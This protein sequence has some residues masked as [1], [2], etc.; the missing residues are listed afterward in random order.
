MQMAVYLAFRGP[1]LLR[2]AW[3]FQVAQAHTIGVGIPVNRGKAQYAFIF[4]ADGTIDDEPERRGDPTFTS[5]SERLRG[6]PQPPKGYLSKYIEA[7]NQALAKEMNET[8]F[9]QRLK[10]YWAS[11]IMRLGSTD[12]CFKPSL[13]GI[14]NWQEFSRYIGEGN[15]YAGDVI[16]A[17]GMLDI[18]D[19]GSIP[20][21][22]YLCLIGDLASVKSLTAEH[23]GR[24]L[25]T[26][27]DDKGNSALHFACMGGH[28][29]IA[30][31]LLREK[32]V[33][34]SRPNNVGTLPL[35]WLFMF[36]DN[37]IDKMAELLSDLENDNMVSAG[38]RIRLHFLWL[39]G[40]P[41]HWAVSCRNRAAVQSLLRIGVNIDEEYQ[42]YTALAKA[43]ELHTPEIV[44]LLLEN[45]AQFKSIGPFGRSAM[46]FVA[47]NAP[48]I[49]RRI[50]HGT[51][52]GRNQDLKKAVRETICKLE[53]FGCN[54]NSTDKHGNTPLHKAVA[55]PLERGDM[56]D[57]Y[58]ARALIQNDADR[59]VQ[60]DDGDTIL[61]LAIKSYWCD[62]PN[63]LDL[64]KLLLDDSIP[65]TNETPL[66]ITQ[67]DRNGRHTLL[68]TAYVG[69]GA[70]YIRLLTDKISGDRDTA[71]AALLASDNYGNNFMTL[72]ETSFEEKM[73]FVGREMKRLEDIGLGVAPHPDCS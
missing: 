45:G 66:Q 8:Y 38:L 51:R 53:F 22:H 71:T 35:H 9:S 19:Q 55:S 40:P 15:S 62:R 59:N 52:H 67:R 24:E 26:L 34:K 10:V 42:G 37:D 2:S 14:K 21:L 11:T 4:A 60:N 50:L 25:L 29:G 56:D 36:P 18:T 7:C 58:V 28:T 6:V 65:L 31:Y 72:A 44:H 54:I 70:T 43:V 5:V 32:S 3:K 17:E 46:H 61:H 69:D 63:H 41:I 57:L 48:I 47:G 23:H 68:V 20:V 16:I 33:A 13:P 64:F 27:E 1:P 12:L 73:Q 39:R 49:K 30:L